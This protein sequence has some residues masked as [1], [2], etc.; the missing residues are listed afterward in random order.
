MSTSNDICFEWLTKDICNIN[1]FIDKLKDMPVLL[2]GC[3]KWELKYALLLSFLNSL[4]S[5]GTP[6]PPPQ[7]KLRNIIGLFGDKFPM[8]DKILLDAK[9]ARDGILEWKKGL[10]QT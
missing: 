4:L 3:N 1:E 10:M 8:L 5:T 7:Q 6:I 2:T 9:L